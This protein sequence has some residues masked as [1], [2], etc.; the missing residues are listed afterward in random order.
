MGSADWMPRNLDRRVEIMFPVENETLKE[1]VIRILEI[2]LEDNES[3]HP[4]AG[5]NLRKEDKRGKVLVNSRN[6]S[7]GRPL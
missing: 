2:E 1:Q 6:S 4:P 5:R 7:A 3:P